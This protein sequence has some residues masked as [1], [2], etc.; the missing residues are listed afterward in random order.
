M[1]SN[2]RHCAAKAVIQ[3]HEGASRHIALGAIERAATGGFVLRSPGAS[4]PSR[5]FWLSATRR[6]PVRRYA[7]SARSHFLDSSSSRGARGPRVTVVQARWRT[8]SAGGAAAYVTRCASLLG[9]FPLLRPA[10][11]ACSTRC[12]LPTLRSWGPPPARHLARAPTSVI[13]RRAG[14]APPGV[15]PSAQTLGLTAGCRFCHPRLG[16][17]I[18]PVSFHSASTL[19]IRP[20]LLSAAVG[21]LPHNV[22]PFLWAKWGGPAAE[23]FR[24]HRRHPLGSCPASSR[25]RCWVCPLAGASARTLGHSPASRTLVFLQ[26]RRA[27]SCLF[28]VATGLHPGRQPSVSAGGGC[29]GNTGEANPSSGGTSTGLASLA[30]RGAHCHHPPRGPSAIPV[31]APQLKR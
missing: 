3:L 26:L 25:L 8:N 7:A 10:T 1:L 22:W 24:A 18:W 19:N 30:P 15:S 31:P 27:S 28:R 11:P 14:Q 12:G 13:I 21:H 29:S 2:A 20:T 17:I 9:P 5:I 16:G 4:R 23:G 6:N